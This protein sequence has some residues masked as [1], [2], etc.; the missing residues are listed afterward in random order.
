MLYS[1]H[2]SSSV[3]SL[4]HV[5]HSPSLTSLAYSD[6]STYPPTLVDEPGAVD[7]LDES[8]IIIVYVDLMLQILYRN[9]KKL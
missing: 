3:L 2:P 4:H 9:L 7:L 5:P 6:I 8:D 1:K